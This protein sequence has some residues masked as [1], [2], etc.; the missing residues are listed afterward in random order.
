MPLS[1]EDANKIQQIF[2]QSHDALSINGYCWKANSTAKNRNIDNRACFVFI[3][4][5]KRNHKNGIMFYQ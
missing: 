2:F 5:S 1:Q 3:F 4:D